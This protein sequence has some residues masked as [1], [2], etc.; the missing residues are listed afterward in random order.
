MCYITSH[1][2]TLCKEQ[3]GFKLL[4]VLLKE[5]FKNF[6][7]VFNRS[8]TGLGQHEGEQL[9]LQTELYL[10][11]QMS[12][13]YSNIYIIVRKS[14][15]YSITNRYN[16]SKCCRGWMWSGWMAICWYFTDPTNLICFSGR[17]ISHWI[18][19]ITRKA[20][21]FSQLTVSRI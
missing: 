7:F 8:C 10:K 13:F 11:W 15:V 5:S 14:P 21:M 12:Y 17:L 3:F 18:A 1:K 20:L 6:P 9:L 16:S 19:V 2:I 4:F